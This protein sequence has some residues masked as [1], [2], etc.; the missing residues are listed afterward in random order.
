MTRYV[1]IPRAF[2]ETIG[3][4][5]YLQP[6]RKEKKKSFALKNVR[7]CSANVKEYFYFIA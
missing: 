1:W 2:N 4:R 5:V 7:G 6:S 3:G